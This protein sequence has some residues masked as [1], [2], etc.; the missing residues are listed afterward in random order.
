[1]EKTLGLEKCCF[2]VYTC[3]CLFI[4]E[5]DSQSVQRLPACLYLLD[6]PPILSRS[7]G[8]VQSERAYCS[9]V[10]CDKSVSL[11]ICLA[12]VTVTPYLRNWKDRR[13]RG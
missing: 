8:Y 6:I 5:T 7:P 3:I 4:C 9:L 13:R 1:M 10:R 12:S 2:E 11:S